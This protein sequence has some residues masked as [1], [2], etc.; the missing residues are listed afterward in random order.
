MGLYENMGLYADTDSVLLKRTKE[1]R[2]TLL[3][4]TVQTKTTDDCVGMYEKRRKKLHVHVLCTWYDQESI[5][6]GFLV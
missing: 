4:T 1:V 5:I 3:K 6:H 2:S